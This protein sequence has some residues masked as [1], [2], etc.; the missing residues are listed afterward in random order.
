MRTHARYMWNLSFHIV[1]SSLSRF[2][3]ALNQPIPSHTINTLRAIHFAFSLHHSTVPTQVKP[4]HFLSDVYRKSMLF[5]SFS[6]P[7]YL[8]CSFFSLLIFTV[9]YLLWFKSH[10]LPCLMFISIS[11][12]SRRFVGPLFVR[13]S[14][15]LSLYHKW[16][17]SRI[18]FLSIVPQNLPPHRFEISLFFPSSLFLSFHWCN[19]LTLSN[20]VHPLVIKQYLLALTSTHT[21]PPCVSSALT[22][23][24]RPFRIICPISIP[25]QFPNPT[26][27]QSHFPV[28]F[29]SNPIPPSS[30]P[31]H[32]IY[33][34]LLSL[35]TKC[36]RFFSDTPNPVVVLI[37]FYIY[38]TLT[39]SPMPRY[40]C[41]HSCSY[42]SLPP[43]PTTPQRI[44]FA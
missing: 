29:F 26:H 27:S 35:T 24:L 14:Y 21:C 30:F 16:Q 38:I 1:D 31:S 34:S 19:A 41:S 9:Y 33:L 44:F 37:R 40:P 11:N 28:F 6:I 7:S 43:S 12:L 10:Y 22:I 32:S 20:H 4:T 23:S 2:S 18:C 42:P 15:T 5:F 25:Y 8:S 36:T 17:I 13:L 3:S 39:Y